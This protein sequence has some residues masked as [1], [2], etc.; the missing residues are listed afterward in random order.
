[1][2]YIYAISDIHGE[3]EIFEEVFKLINLIDKENK[4]VLLGD[5]ISR[6]EEADYHETL[7]FIKELEEKYQGQIIVLMGNHELMLLED[8]G[9]KTDSIIKWL[10]SLPYLYE[11]EVC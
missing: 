6:K 11:T 7:S 9:N 3:L 1:M 5:Y 2:A 10:K 4:L 8:A